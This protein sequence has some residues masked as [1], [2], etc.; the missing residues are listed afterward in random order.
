MDRQVHKLGQREVASVKVL[1]RNQFAEEVTWEDEEDM[2]K[3]YPHLFESG[4]NVVSGTK[5]SSYHF[6]RLCVSMLL[7]A[8]VC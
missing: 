2:E 7:L 3:R 5:F 6:I 1:F 8:F 4:E